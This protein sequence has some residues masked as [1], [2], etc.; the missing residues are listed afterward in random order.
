MTNK[1]VI[2]SLK[3][4]LADSYTLYLKTQ[5]YHWNVT[6]PN[7]KGLHELFQLQYEDMALAIDEVAERIRS[8]GDFAPGSY[9]AYTK[10]TSIKE[11]DDNTKSADMVKNLANDQDL[12]I[13]TLNKALSAAQDAEDESTADLLIGRISIHE[14]NRWMLKSSL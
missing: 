12:I 10:L 11:A 14:K 2:E 13:V 8:L 6:G 3:A 7:F 5:N 1:P 9:K 4:V